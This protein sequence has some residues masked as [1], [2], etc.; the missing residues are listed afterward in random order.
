[1]RLSV[2]LLLMGVCISSLF[3]QDPITLTPN[4]GKRGTSFTV[5]ITGVNTAFSVNSTTLARISKD[6]TSIDITGVAA[7]ATMFNGTLNLPEQADTGLYNA[8]IYQD[9]ENGTSW[10]CSNCFT[11]ELNC[12]LNIQAQVTQI[13]CF[14]D[15]TGQIKLTIEGAAGATNLLWSNA[16][17]SDSLTNLGPGLYQVT[18]TDAG[19]CSSS[20]FITVIQPTA[21]NA[22][23]FRDDV[24]F[25]NGNNGK[26]TVRP[27]G[28]L[29]PYT[30]VWSNGVTDESI[31]NVSP[32]LYS[33]TVT[34]SRGCTYV[35]SEQFLNFNCTITDTITKVD[36]ACFGDTSGSAT[37]VTSFENP[38]LTYF[39]SNGATTATASGLGVGKYFVTVTDF[40]KCP[41][42][43]SIVIFEPEPLSIGFSAQP[44]SKVGAMDGQIIA[45]PTGGQGPYNLTWSNDQ[46]AD[47]L[48]GLA[49]GTYEVTVTDAAGCTLTSTTVVADIDCSAFALSVD[50][51]NDTLGD[52]NIS[53]NGGVGDLTFVWLKDGAQVDSVQNLTGADPGTYFI[54]VTDGRGCQAQDTVMLISTNVINTVLTAQ[55][56]L[57]PNPAYGS[58][59]I[60]LPAI[61]RG[62][63]LQVYNAQGQLMHRQVMTDVTQEVLI[64]QWPHGL[65]VV[66]GIL[67]SNIITK[68]IQVGQ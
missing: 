44:I 29:G 65:Y 8:T 68:K 18:V 27:Q 54:Q 1:M 42:V 64:H 28:G 25:Y 19:G 16:A 5:N 58:F 37:I 20:R 62:A 32:G 33:Y 61:M 23:T 21:V 9:T 46:M 51:I 57:F 48:A 35:G 43:D 67:G 17:T 4:T 30:I 52:I 7:D 13:A 63:Q 56:R 26:A 3:S 45:F 14:G 2:F 55:T 34:D 6:T 41:L 11:V 66:R 24:T 50:S 47:T 12:N 60:H 39:W 53:V 10:S 36:L 40:R 22:V 49:A 59:F 38:P 15:S 31:L